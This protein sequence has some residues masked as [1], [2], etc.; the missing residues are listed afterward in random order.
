MQLSQNSAGIYIN[1]K[2]SATSIVVRY[3]VTGNQAML[4]MPATGVS[5]V[6]LYGHDING[7]WRW[8]KGSWQFGDT[9]EYRFSNLSLSAK[10]EEFRLYLPLYNTVSWMTI[11]MPE[12]ATFTWLSVSGEPS[13]VAYGTSIL[14]G[15]CTSRPGLAWT[16]I[17]GRKLERP[18][19]NLGFS[20]NGQLEP[21]RK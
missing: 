15:G 3:K 10:E 16:N 5:G 20:G 12:E 13:I 21:D 9:C 8:A 19:I 17:L 2:T 7:Q 4:H 1:F 14:Q 18:V 6:D 11:G